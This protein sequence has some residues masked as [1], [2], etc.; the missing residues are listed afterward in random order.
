M[1]RRRLLAG[2]AMLAAVPARAGF[3]QTA[4]A[5]PPRIAILMAVKQGDPEGEG[6]FNALRTGLAERG[7]VDGSTAKLEVV[8][9]GGEIARIRGKLLVQMILV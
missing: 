8:W 4:P 5:A 6:R 1:R 2:G 7:W 9:A 3:A